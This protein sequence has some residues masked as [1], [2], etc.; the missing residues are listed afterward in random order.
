MT[1]KVDT[2]EYWIADAIRNLRHAGKLADK[3]DT[4]RVA[5]LKATA[6]AAW[7]AIRIAEDLGAQMLEPIAGY[8]AEEAQ[9]S[10]TY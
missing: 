6:F 5:D 3:P 9:C 7:Q 4:A 2:R 8:I 1:D 10:P